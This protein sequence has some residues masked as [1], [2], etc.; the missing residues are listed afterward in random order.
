MTSSLPFAIPCSRCGVIHTKEIGYA[1]PDAA[2]VIREEE[3]S[4]ID[5]DKDHLAIDQRSF[6]IRA[7]APIPLLFAFPPNLPTDEPAAVMRLE[8]GAEQRFGIGFWIEVNEADYRDYVECE[9]AFLA[10]ESRPHA[11]YEGRIANQF[12]LLGHSLGTAVRASFRP[13]T[14]APITTHEYLVAPA[15]R[16]NVRWGSR[17]EIFALDSESW[18][19]RLQ[20]AGLTAQ[21]H[22]V[23]MERCAHPSEPEPMGDPFAADLEMHGWEVLTFEETGWAPHVFTE[24]PSMGDYVKLFIRFLG[25][26]PKG[27]GGVCARNAGWWIRLDDASGGLWTGTLFSRP[28]QGSPLS[29]GARVW[30]R[31][32]SVIGH[33]LPGT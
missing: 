23:W 28:V 17:P 1:L 15:D 13:P 21:T 27:G 12:D 7:Y 6:F 14:Y 5:G 11:T 16:T 18:L 20:Q 31:P 29:H 32:D 24:P 4:R 9:V 22:A 2:L 25:I 26:D 30:F 10:G 19:G 8:D 3:A 33:Q